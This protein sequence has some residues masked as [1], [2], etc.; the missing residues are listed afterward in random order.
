MS[1]S[2]YLGGSLWWVGLVLLIGRLYVTA[3][4]TN[5]IKRLV[6]QEAFKIAIESLEGRVDLLSKDGLIKFQRGERG[7]WHTSLTHYPG[8]PKSSLRVIVWDDGSVE[9]LDHP[10]G[11]PNKSLSTQSLLG[12]FTLVAESLASRCDLFET[13]GRIELHRTDD[14]KWYAH[15]I[16]YRGIPIIGS[17]YFFVQDDG[18]SNKAGCANEITSADGGCRV[19]SAF[20]AQWPAA[21][22]FL[23]YCPLAPIAWH[24]H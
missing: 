19:L 23:R 21:A 10:F 20:L 7:C 15:A 9:Q 11:E 16:G 24:Q 6:A 2:K 12:A 13:G 3:S 5:Q 18:K 22:E 17:A 1:Q 14:N 4:E 8:Q